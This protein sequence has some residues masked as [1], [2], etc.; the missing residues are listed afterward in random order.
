ML[1]L[2]KRRISDSLWSA[3]NEEFCKKFE[4]WNR[5]YYRWPVQV[6]T[7]NGLI[8]V[9]DSDDKNIFIGQNS[10][11]KLYLNGIEA[12]LKELA[13]VYHLENIAFESGDVVIDCGANVGEIG[14]F[15]SR[16]N[17]D[18]HAFEPSSEE[19]SCAR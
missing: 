5:I 12:R 16:Y 18:Y 4:I 6:R 17:V 10:R 1:R 9:T 3:G 15:L 14:M 19:T 2:L 7:E 8:V 13:K 11:I